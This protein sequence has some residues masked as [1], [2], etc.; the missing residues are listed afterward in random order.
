M[1]LFVLVDRD[2]SSTHYWID[3]LA[4]FGSV[5]DRVVHSVRKAFITST[6]FEWSIFF[7][8]TDSRHED[9]FAVGWAIASVVGTKWATLVGP[10]IATLAKFI[11]FSSN[12]SVRCWCD[13]L[14]QLMKRITKTH[15]IKTFGKQMSLE[16]MHHTQIAYFYIWQYLSCVLRLS[17]CQSRCW[18]YQGTLKSLLCGNSWRDYDCTRIGND[19][20]C[21]K[22]QRGCSKS[23]LLLK[24]LLSHD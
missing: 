6:V 2:S 7:E 10:V 13:L 5:L 23:R 14:T 17:M 18:L 22:L 15:Y 16:F 3:V 20:P 11:I 24:I 1:F 9:F 8:T 4:V 12:Q 21:I 19:A